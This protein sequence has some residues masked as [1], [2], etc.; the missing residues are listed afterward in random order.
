[1]LGQTVEVVHVISRPTNKTVELPGEFVPYL[2]VPIHAKISG[3]VERVEVDRGSAVQ[4]GQLLA[5]SV[6]P[7]LNAQR[8]EARAKVSVG[9]PQKLEA[10]ARVVA[11]QSTYERMK[12]AAATPGAIA[13]NELVV[14][15][16]K[17][18]DA[19]RTRFEAAKASIQAAQEAM[20]AIEEL[21]VYLPVTAPFSGMITQEMFI[22]VLL[23]DLGKTRSQCSSS[24]PSIALSLLCQCP[25]QMS[26][27][28][29]RAQRSDSPFVHTLAKSFAERLA[30]SL[31]LL[32]RRQ[33]RC[34]SSWMSRIRE[35]AWLSACTPRSN[36]RFAAMALPFGCLRVA[37]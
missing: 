29:P 14:Q 9:E 19:E 20:R 27:L 6:A 1:M 36:G 34:L 30:E 18:L 10:E 17:Q 22:P 11:A 4:E 16:E 13:G 3:F 33:D 5:T 25:R 2:S 26:P 15:A 21:E 24:R 32:N 23:S 28:L 37:S 35:G 7:E 31:T 8:A 12:V